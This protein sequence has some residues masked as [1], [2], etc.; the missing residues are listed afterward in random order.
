MKDKIM[1]KDHINEHR[2][3]DSYHVM[4]KKLLTVLVTEKTH[5]NLIREVKLDF[6]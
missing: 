5:N 6:L 3:Y 2:K 4:Q 1:F